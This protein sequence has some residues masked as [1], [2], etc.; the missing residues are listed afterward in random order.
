MGQL[1]HT[2]SCVTSATNASS[3]SSSNGA[4][5]VSNAVEPKSAIAPVG[6]FDAQIP[7]SPSAVARR[8]LWD[9]GAG[10]AFLDKREKAQY[11]NVHRHVENKD[12]S[13]AAGDETSRQGSSTTSRLARW[14]PFTR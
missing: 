5:V 7:L 9:L 8:K 11:A 6:L 1:A 14:L 2:T 4:L 12:A 13:N 3:S 10:H